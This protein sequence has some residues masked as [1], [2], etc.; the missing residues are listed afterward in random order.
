MDAG[1]AEAAGGAARAVP[2]GG[3]RDGAM[4]EDRRSAWEQDPNPGT[5]LINYSR[6]MWISSFQTLNAGS[7]KNTEVLPKAPEGGDAG[8]WTG[9]E[10]KQKVNYFV[11]QTTMILS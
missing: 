4:E 8:T 7:I 3:R 2:L 11:T 6:M 5:G 1:G 9:R 10:D